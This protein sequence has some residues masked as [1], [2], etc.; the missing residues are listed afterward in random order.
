MGRWY[1][2]QNE[3]ILMF[4]KGKARPINNAGT[5]DV[6]FSPDF[7]KDKVNKK[8]LHDT[9]KPISVM[10]T[11]II[12]SSDPNEIVCDPFAGIFTT[13]IASVKNN[14]KCILM[15]IDPI[16]FNIGKEL[17]ENRKDK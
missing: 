6:I 7:K 13:G 2:T 14:R 16:Y 8:N 11:L 5:S 3:L 12:N 10:E 17:I 15:E 1:M 9:Q 4:R